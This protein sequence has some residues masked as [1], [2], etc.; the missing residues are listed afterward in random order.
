VIAA[1][2]FDSPQQLN[3]YNLNRCRSSHRYPKVN[4]VIHHLLERRIAEKAQSSKWETAI[5]R[6]A[7]LLSILSVLLFTL[8][9]TAYSGVIQSTSLFFLLAASSCIGTGFAWLISI[10]LVVERRMDRKSLAAA[11]E[12]DHDMLQD[13]LNTVVELDQRIKDDH[14]AAMYR[15]AIE[16]QATGLVPKLRP[17]NPLKKRS[18]NAHLLV[19][20]L[21]GILAVNFYI[22]KSPLQT[23]A[24]NEAKAADEA[25]EQA[26][27]D[28]LQPLVIPDE[29]ITPPPDSEE[30][31]GSD[32]GEIRISEPGRDLRITAHEDVPLLIEAASDRPLASITWQTQVNDSKEV[33]RPLPELEDPRYAV[34]QPTLNP[35]QLGLKEWDVT[36]YR[37]TANAID[38][39]RYGSSSYFV[40]IVPGAEALKQ[41]PHAGYESLEELTDLIHRQQQVIRSTE[42]LTDSGDT[43]QQKT[44]DSLAEREIGLAS[45]GRSVQEKLSRRLDRKTLRKFASSIEAASTEFTNAETALLER[46]QTEAEQTE[47]SALM[48]LVDARRELANLIEQYPESFAGSALSELEDQVTLSATEADPE[49]A[50]LL[51]QLAQESQQ[52]NEASRGL[53]ELLDQQEKLAQEAAD[54]EEDRIPAL[55]SPDLATKQHDI[56][57]QFDSLRKE[58][59]KA[60]QNRKG[61]SEKTASSM[62]R[63][64]DQLLENPNAASVSVEQAKNNL[65]KLNETLEQLQNN[66]EQFQA[67]SLQQRIAANREAYRAIERTAEKPNTAE[68]SKAVDETQKLLQ[69]IPDNL[70]NINEAKKNASS[71]DNQK[72]TGTA[73]PKNEDNNQAKQNP[74]A[75]SV[76]ETKKQVT[77]QTEALKTASDSEQRAET[78]KSLDQSLSKIAESLKQQTAKRQQGHDQEQMASQLKQ[79]Q[80]QS[81]ALQTARE[82]VQDAINREENIQSKTTENLGI[83][84]QFQNLARDQL[85]LEEDMTTARE[86]NPDGFETVAIQADKVQK[87]MQETTRALNA[88]QDNA[89]NTSQQAV[90]SLEQ[91]DQSLSKQQEQTE[92]AQQSNLAQQMEQLINQLSEIEKQPDDFSTAEKQQTAGQCQSVGSL[93]CKNPGSSGSGGKAA[94]SGSP[95]DANQPDQEP[96]KPNGSQ[97]AEASAPDGQ[98]SPTGQPSGA[99]QPATAGAPAPAGVPSGGQTPE[100]ALQDATERLAESNGTQETSEAAGGLKQQMQNLAK[101][102]GMQPGARQ[103]Q[104][105]QGNQ[106][107]KTAG[108]GDSLSPGGRES[109]LRG[110]AQLESAARQGEQGNLTPQA[111]RALRNNGLADI[112]TGIQGQYGYNDGTQILIQQVKQEL[113]GPKINIDLKTVNELRA[114]IQKAQRDF[115]IKADAPTEPESTLRNDPAKYPSAYRESIQ[116]YFQ[117]LSEDKPQ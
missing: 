2:F 8:G 26:R 97:L 92:S 43:D 61:L 104:G 19:M 12:Q 23:L 87:E 10:I 107:N 42:K 22:T 16:K 45:A 56:A 113:E 44:M 64:S 80:E 39:T 70:G 60:F 91:L 11:V 5:K 34:F 111:G 100:Q 112:V 114:Q 83:R 99:G 1:C 116:T 90:E 30:Q 58:F 51:K 20:L 86:Q 72:L 75:D 77:Q 103:A 36:R 40:E 41:L 69:E 32:W 25:K 105:K 21:L 115:V 117:A 14:S 17:A 50:R 81:Q 7:T 13:R 78:A 108:Q 71:S 49:L 37:A 48:H 65:Q 74:Q 31:A 94:G 63:A 54:I 98:S 33:T 6:T 96:P 18:V 47:E 57:V 85:L 88:G 55:P 3:H 66:Y 89:P 9:L 106:G 73:P 38:E 62:S 76:A 27:Q 110:L 15:D 84:D 28:N 68:I 46:A 29:S 109:L 79:L 53:N 4:P 52:I 95:A 93:A 102:M 101:A 67:N 24:A 59:P 35:K 82:F